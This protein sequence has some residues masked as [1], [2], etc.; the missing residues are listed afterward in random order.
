MKNKY[1][2]GF[3][4]ITHKSCTDGTFSALVAKK[5]CR[6]NGLIEPTIIFE[7]YGKDIKQYSNEI[8][9][10][11]DVIMCDFSYDRETIIDLHDN[12]TK[13][14][15]VLDH[16]AS[17]E[18]ELAGLDYCTFDMK[19]SGAMLMWD[20]F[21]PGQPAPRIVE[22]VQ[23]RDI[24]NWDLE[25]SHEF[26]AGLKLHKDFALLQDYDIEYVFSDKLVDT[27][28]KE[29]TSV[30]TY[31]RTVIDKVVRGTLNKKGVTAGVVMY[32][33]GG[34]E[35]PVINSANLISEIGNELSKGHPFSA[36]YFFT[37]HGEIVFSLRSQ[38]DGA[39]VSEVARSYGGGGH[40]NSGAMSF[41][42]RDIKLDVFF[43]TK[44]LDK[45]LLNKGV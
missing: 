13:S 15:V 1:K 11:R 37:N 44:N 24:W 36:Q 17:A 43:A 29:G 3:T 2:N 45:S 16:H 31:Q 4:L 32:N 9:N 5:F 6:E 39:D 30:L 25:D 38:P 27:C 7:Q 21:Y 8:I 28:I 41:D 34:Y 40:R 10:N 12:V 20:Y 22:F 14:F 26:S 18:K 23:D 33:I 35:V 42:I 19:K